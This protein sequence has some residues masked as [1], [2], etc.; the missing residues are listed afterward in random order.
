MERFV[1]VVM[2][3]ASKVINITVVLCEKLQS[4]NGI[5]S[6]PILFTPF[7]G[8]ILFWMQFLYVPFLE[9]LNWRCYILG[10]VG[11]EFNG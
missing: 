10:L 6:L 11:M 2:A 4:V 3:V 5:P 9:R 8:A 7:D 1:D